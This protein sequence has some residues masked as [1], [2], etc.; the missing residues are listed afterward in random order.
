MPTWQFGIPKQT[1]QAIG[2]KKD[3]QFPSGVDY[4]SGQIYPV[5]ITRKCI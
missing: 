2:K 1:S 4:L 5:E 3:K